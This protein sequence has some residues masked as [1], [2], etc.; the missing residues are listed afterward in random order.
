[1]VP[2]AD[3]ASLARSFLFQR[4]K[5]PVPMSRWRTAK[6][7]RNLLNDP[8]TR[9]STTDA[10]LDYLDRCRTE[11]EACEILTIVFLTS[12]EA[13]PARTTLVSRLRCPSILADIILERTYGKGHGL[14]GWA[15]AH[16]GPAP[17]D[18]EGGSY[19]EEHKTAHV[20]PIYASNLEKLERVSRYPVL[21]HWAYEW[22]VLRDKLGTRFTRYPHY[23]DNV[24]DTRAGII[25]QYW[26][27]M[28]DVYLSAYLR[29]LAYAVSEWRMPRTI[30]E[31]YCVEIAHGI[32]GLFDVEPGA[33]PAWLSDFPERF[34]PTGVDFAPLVR[35]LVQ[36]ARAEGM[37]LVS[38]DT[39]IASSV[40]KFANL[41]L[42]AHLVTPDYQL[43]EGAFL[44]EKM[45]WLPIAN[46]FELKGMPAGT[47][48]E[49]ASTNGKAGNEVP[50]CHC[51]LPIPFGTW[52]SDYFSMG[53]RISA[54]YT[55]PNT[56]IRCTRESIDCIAPDGKVASRT[57]IWND[58]WAPTYPKEGSTR[59]GTATMIDEAMLV[60]AQRRF[61]RNLAWVASLRIWDRKTEYG[62][63]AES[64]RTT[65]VLD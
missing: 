58:D 1:M 29:T 2:L 24:S 19:F 56:E 32:A 49:E 57:R 25:G 53:L 16:S 18:F 3:S 50:V 31:G 22:K 63:Y 37:R 65:F 45:L 47:T 55:V 52:Q 9:S 7:I 62:E 13:R 11:S 21:Q 14:G 30:A 64:R 39:P 8:S 36:T 4:L 46:T 43:P 34:C 61:G 10:L 5:W 59:C 20:P 28:R 44:Y 41:T 6:E 48:I 54:S 51:L 23:F 42:T 26:Q 15:Q 40:Q 35:D 17:A 38:L 27:R 12:A 33:R 60:A